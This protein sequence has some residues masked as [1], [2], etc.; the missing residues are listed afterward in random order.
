MWGY[1]CDLYLYCTFHS[2]CLQS[3]FKRR[4]I[5][6]QRQLRN[7]SSLLDDMFYL[8]LFSRV[9]IRLVLGQDF[10]DG[11]QLKPPLYLGNT[12]P[13]EDNICQCK[14]ETENKNN[15]LEA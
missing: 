11:P 15:T 8:S 2:Q 14:A 6:I 12:V 9:Q 1:T 3:A 10:Q 7:T 4:Q 5:D 13:V